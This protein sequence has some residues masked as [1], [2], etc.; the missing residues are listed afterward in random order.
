[1]SC[2]WILL[3]QWRLIISCIN[4]AR[5]RFGSW[6]LRKAVMVKNFPNARMSR[7]IQSVILWWILY[8]RNH[9]SF[10]KYKTQIIN[11]RGIHICNPLAHPKTDKRQNW[12]WVKD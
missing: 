9:Q 3:L 6:R 10:R 8:A 7:C 4:G 1:V 12:F 2:L 11:D 5:C